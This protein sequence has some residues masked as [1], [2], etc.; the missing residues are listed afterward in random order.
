MLKGPGEIIKSLVVANHIYKYE[1][2]FLRLVF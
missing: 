2:N 1:R